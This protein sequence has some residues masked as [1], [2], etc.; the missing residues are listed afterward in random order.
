MKICTVSNGFKNVLFIEFSSYKYSSVE[1]VP[2]NWDL[3]PRPL[4]A[5]FAV[6]V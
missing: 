4:I 3:K 1:D 2:C 5:T 6:S